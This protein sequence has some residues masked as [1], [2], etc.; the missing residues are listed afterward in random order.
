[1]TSTSTYLTEI[2]TPTAHG[3]YVSCQFINRSR[4]GH[5]LM[6]SLALLGRSRH[7]AYGYG[8]LRVIVS[9]V[10]VVTRRSLPGRR[11]VKRGKAGLQCRGTGLTGFL[12]TTASSLFVPPS[13]HHWPG[14]VGEDKQKEVFCTPDSPCESVRRSRLDRSPTYA[15]AAAQF[16]CSSSKGQPEKL[17]GLRVV[18]LRGF[19][20]ADVG[21]GASVVHGYTVRIGSTVRKV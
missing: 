10:V 7:R 8:R 12:K 17:G 14:F 6:T 15:V 1:M 21:S 13:A 18:I 19:A 3:G 20:R 11:Q 9:S 2:S 4:A 5:V 16:G